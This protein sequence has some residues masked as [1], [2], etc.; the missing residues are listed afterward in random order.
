MGNHQ[1]AIK[2]FNKSIEIDPELS[3]GYYRRGF[4]KLASK[5]FHEAVLDFKESEKFE[6]K[7]DDKGNAGIP[8][9]LGCCKHALKDYHDALHH[10]DI[11]I[12]QDPSNTEFLMHRAQ[13]YYDLGQFDRSIEDLN[14][15]LN[16][17]QDDAQLYYRLG[18]S[19]YADEDYK[20][21]VR[22]LKQSLI[23]RPFIS[24]ESDIYYHIGLS[25]CNVE[26]FEKS[27]FPFSR[28]IEMIPSEI[29]YIHERAKA[30]QMIEDHEKA[31]ADFDTVIK[32][33]PKNAHA[34]FRRAFSHKALK[35]F[36]QAADDF[37]QAK[38]LDPLNPKMVVNYKKL[39]GITCI[40]LCKP[41][42]EK[43]F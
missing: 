13:C 12:E 41:G 14:T 4:S 29:R 40:V 28:C 36:S 2:D 17:T 34:H 9:G 30:Y 23:C 25:Y 24:Y 38:A 16:I 20:A 18:L 15:A 26:K 3:E 5:N 42:E 19:Q 21:C 39:K 27:I 35:N 33:N 22:S 37:E 6:V 32:K 1:L 43:V 7:E 11:A 31:V 8:D 10:Y